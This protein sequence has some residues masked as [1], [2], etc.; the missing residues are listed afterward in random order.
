MSEA[1]RKLSGSRNDLWKVT[2][3]FLTINSLMKFATY[4]D[5]GI[6]K[7]VKICRNE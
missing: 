4:A 2:A 7:H 1:S 6:N 5:V 3:A